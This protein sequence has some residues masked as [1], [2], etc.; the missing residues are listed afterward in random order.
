LWRWGI[1]D[2]VVLLLEDVDDLL[3]ALVF[4]GKEEEGLISGLSSTK[5][6]R[7][8]ERKREREEEESAM[9]YKAGG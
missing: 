8:T 7:N 9:L 6:K 4:A 5:R 3:E 2:V 1:A